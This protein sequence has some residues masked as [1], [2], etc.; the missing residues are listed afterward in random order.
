ME[1]PEIDKE[2][3]EIPKNPELEFGFYSIT[4]E[5]SKIFTSTCTK[6]AGCLLQSISLAPSCIRQRTRWNSVPAS[7]IGYSHYDLSESNLN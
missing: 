1:M 5:L 2:E 4:Y 7:A 3:L 6:P